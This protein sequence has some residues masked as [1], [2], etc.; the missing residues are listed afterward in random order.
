MSCM[1]SPLRPLNM[2][3]CACVRQNTVAPGMMLSADEG[4]RH[5]LDGTGADALD[6]ESAAIARVAAGSAAT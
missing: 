6:M 2:V 4:E 3:G 5:R 1:L